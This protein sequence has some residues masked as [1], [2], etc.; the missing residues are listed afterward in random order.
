MWRRDGFLCRDGMYTNDG[1]NRSFL[2]TLTR[3][4]SWLLNVYSVTN[5][6]VK[7]CL[8]AQQVVLAHREKILSLASRT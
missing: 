5:F 8:F 1:P 6:T 4:G 2:F 3:I 7:C